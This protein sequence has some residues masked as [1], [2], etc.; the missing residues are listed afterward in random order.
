MSSF[1]GV[2]G[3][4]KSSL[5][6]HEVKCLF[7]ECFNQTSS[8]MI[9]NIKA[10]T[11]F[12][13]LLNQICL[14]CLHSEVRKNPWEEI[15]L[16]SGLSLFL[17]HFFSVRALSRLLRQHNYMK[18]SRKRGARDTDRAGGERDCWITVAC[19]YG[20]VWTLYR[21]SRLNLRLSQ[22][23]STLWSSKA[24]PS[25]FVL[26]KRTSE[27]NTIYHL[28]L[29]K[30]SIF[31]SLTFGNLVRMPSNWGFFSIFLLLIFH[32]SFSSH[33]VWIILFDLGVILYFYVDK[34]GEQQRMKD[35]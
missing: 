4:H 10:L 34:L 3:G 25:V 1:F 22:W 30:K 5:S 20:S 15:S 32:F 26:E 21:I 2:N 31:R 6:W 12:C 28:Q 29:G 11:L 16:S 33:V 27:T 13:A 35:L 7:L 9:T 24:P 23:G 14:Q 18:F 17:Q 8:C 19:H